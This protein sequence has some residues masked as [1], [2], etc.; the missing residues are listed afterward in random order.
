MLLSRKSDIFFINKYRIA[1]WRETL[2]S[3][4]KVQTRP[5]GD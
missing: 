5:V 1:A 4:R 2:A 3:N